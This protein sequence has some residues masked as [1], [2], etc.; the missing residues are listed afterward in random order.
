MSVQVLPYL[1]LVV[2][3]QSISSARILGIFHLP[4]YSHQQLGSK[5]MQELASRGH[6]VTF[7]TPFAPKTQIKNL[8]HIQLQFN[9][10]EGMKL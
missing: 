7:V 10:K 6:E 8:N 1:L 5:L 2:G 9:R 4:S 3:L